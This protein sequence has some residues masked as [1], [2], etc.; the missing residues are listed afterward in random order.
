MTR[1][2][3]NI[4]NEFGPPQ[5][6]GSGI[7]SDSFDGGPC[8]SRDGLM[9]FFASRRAGGYGGDDLWMSIRKS[10][11]DS[12][13][14]PI[15]L[16]ASI[17]S[18]ANDA[19]PRIS[20]D[21][22]T[23]YFCST[24]PEGYGSFDIWLCTRESLADTFHAPVNLGPKI[25]SPAWE[26]LPRI[27]SDELSLYFDSNRPGGFGSFDIWVSK[28]TDIHKSFESPINLDSSV[29]TKFFE[30]GPELLNNSVL[31]FMSDRPGGYGGSDLWLIHLQANGKPEGKAINGGSVINSNAF[32]FGPDIS[33]D[34]RELIFASNREGGYGD[35]DL[36]ITKRNKKKKIK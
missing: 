12:F 8:L 21:G 28:R 18:K 6:F 32:D 5:N 14:K 36:W 33:N 7:N 30:G 23:L 3:N 2:F 19:G 25:N 31:Y 15:N 11:N 9:L 1:S 16:G 24:R 34:A 10:V 17:N 29:N 26:G 20:D 35:F 22:L 27:S 4:E 13:Q